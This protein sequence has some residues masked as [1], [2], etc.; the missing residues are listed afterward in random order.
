MNE[1]I[2][3]ELH[4]SDFMNFLQKIPAEGTRSEKRRYIIT[5]RCKFKVKDFSLIFA[6]KLSLG[7]F[8]SHINA[9]VE[10]AA[11]QLFC[12]DLNHCNG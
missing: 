4:G 12:F 3:T 9:I 2:M 10:A 11:F 8:V 7:F 1:R 6:R 5:T